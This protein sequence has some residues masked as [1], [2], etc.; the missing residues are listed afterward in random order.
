LR[1]PSL[2]G[3]WNAHGSVQHDLIEPVTGAYHQGVAPIEPKPL[4]TPVEAQRRR[5]KALDRWF[6]FVNGERVVK[7]EQ[8]ADTLLF[9]T[10]HSAR[11]KGY[12]LSGKA[13]INVE[14][15]RELAMHNLRTVAAG[16]SWFVSSKDLEDFE[17]QVSPFGTQYRGTAWTLSQLGILALL[18][19]EEWRSALCA[20]CGKLFVRKHHGE[21]CTK[22]CSQ[23]MRTFKA[24]NPR[25]KVLLRDAVKAK[26]PIAAWLVNCESRS[27]ARAGT[28]RT[29]PKA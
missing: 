3:I 1:T 15:I 18:Y 5:L 28:V 4:I 17:I 21:Y 11:A 26:I 9:P 20:W 22:K 16:E 7:A 24:R 29:R 2:I 27:P 6:E 14:Q 10:F 19:G 12:G 13:N 23:R 25:A 8:F